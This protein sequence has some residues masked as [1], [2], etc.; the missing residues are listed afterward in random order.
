MSWV[1]VG[2]TAASVGQQYLSAK[3]AQKDQKA[4][5][6]LAAAKERTSY[7]TGRGGQLQTGA[8]NPYTAMLNGA[9]Q[10]G[11]S[12]LSMNQGIAQ[13]NANNDFRQQQ[14][15]YMQKPQSQSVGMNT[16]S[17]NPWKFIG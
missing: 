9:M 5:N 6:Q 11:I 15:D 16:N 1:A 13:Q 12:G 2:L 17:Y 3:D 8:P 10:G 4:Q 7:I 14:L